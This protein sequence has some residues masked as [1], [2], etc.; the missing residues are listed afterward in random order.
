[1]G[2]LKERWADLEEGWSI[3]DKVDKE[4]EELALWTKAKQILPAWKKA[5]EALVAELSQ[6]NVDR[7]DP[8][9]RPLSRSRIPWSISTRPAISLLATAVTPS[10]SLMEEMDQIFEMAD[11]LADARTPR[12]QRPPAKLKIVS[13]VVVLLAIV[14]SMIF[15]FL[16]ARSI[17]Q[18]MAKGVQL[19]EEVAKGDFSARLNMK[20]KDEIGQLAVALDGMADSLARQANVAEE[21]ARGNLAVEV[22]LSSEKDQLG[23]ALSNMVEKTARGDRP[24]YA[25]RSRMSPPVPRR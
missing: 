25:A 17:A 10:T 16:I 24:G 2:K 1:M 14:I 3:Y 23:Q 12:P 18:P 19:A 5:H 9:R 4:P 7:L 20:R 11:K 13:V 22:K 15:G 6:V 8:S 21:I